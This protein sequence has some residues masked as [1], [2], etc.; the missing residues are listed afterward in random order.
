MKSG[1]TAALDSVRCNR[2]AVERLLFSVPEAAVSLSISRAT[3]WKLVSDGR[4]AAI[5]I[6][7]RTLVRREALDA[8][9][10]NAEAAVTR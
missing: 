3:A 9:I 2:P 10:N 8:F 6:G 5:K 7:G 1:N 4:L